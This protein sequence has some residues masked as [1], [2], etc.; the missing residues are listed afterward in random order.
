MLLI[1]LFGLITA[2]LKPAGIGRMRITQKIKEI[3]PTKPVNLIHFNN[4][5]P[6]DPWGGLPAKFYVEQ[7]IYYTKIESLNLIDSVHLE[8]NK[9]NFLIVEMKDIHKQKL[10]DF[11]ADRKLRKIDQSIPGYLIPFLKVYGYKT[12]DILILY[13][14]EPNILE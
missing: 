1:N 12:Q 3:E 11:I 7:S 5:N 13:G 6:Y 8:D 4:S 14:D 10:L 2:S 9:R